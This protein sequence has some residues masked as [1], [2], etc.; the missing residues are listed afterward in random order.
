[1]HADAEAKATILAQ[2]RL[3]DEA[4]TAAL[5]RRLAGAAGPGDILLLSG[6]L[7]AGKTAFARAFIQARMPE[8]EPV[9]SPTFTLVQTYLTPEA[10][11]W[12]ADLY[13]LGDASE[14]WELGLLEAGPGAILLVEWP[15]MAEGLWPGAA[16]WLRFERAGPVAR[17]VTLTRV[18]GRADPTPLSRAMA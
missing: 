8:P 11:I 5:A 18:D 12:H 7:G 2:T 1:M 13:R 16:H 4:A 6:D 3:P 10:E 9:P 17:D 15:E 14:F